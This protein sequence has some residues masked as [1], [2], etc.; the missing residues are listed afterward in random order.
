MKGASFARISRRWPTAAVTVLFVWGV[1]GVSFVGA[2]PAAAKD[3]TELSIED[4]MAMEVTTTVARK[5]QPVSKT[6][7]A[8]FVISSEDIRRSGATCIPE[9]LR[10]VP[11]FEVARINANKWAISAR[12][13]NGYIANKL[14]VLMDGRTVYNQLYSG[15]YWDIQDTVLEDVARI[16]VIRGPGASL[17]G[18][19][20]VNGVV[21]II[22]KKASETQGVMVA[23]GAGTEERF[24]S[25]LRYG[26]RLGK[27]AYYRMYGKFFD[28]DGGDMPDG[29]ESY[30]DWHYGRG[31]GRIDWKRSDS[32][33]FTFQGDIYDGASGDLATYV[34]F[35]P[36]YYKYYDDNTKQSGGNLLGRW[37]H[38]PSSDEDITLQLYFDQTN[39]SYPVLSETRDTYDADFQQRFAWGRRQEV[40]WGLGYRLVHAQIDNSDIVV[41]QNDDRWDQLFSFFVQDEIAILPQKLS[42]LIGSKF[43]KN[44]YTGWETQPNVRLLWTPNEQH[45]VWSAVSRAVRT[46]SQAE[47]DV[48]LVQRIYPGSPYNTMVTF[49]GTEDFLSEQLTAYEAGYRFHPQEAFTIDLAVFYNEY[50]QLLGVEMGTPRISP[51]YIVTPLVASNQLKGNTRGVELAL[52]YQPLPWWRLMGAYTYLEM[53]LEGANS[54]ITETYLAAEGENPRHQVSLRSTM[55]LPCGWALDLWGRYVDDLPSQNVSSYITM[56]ARLGWRPTDNWEFSLV[57]QN[58]LSPSHEEFISEIIEFTPTKVERSVY[59]K[60]KWQF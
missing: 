45:T 26:G 14:L 44:D 30:D 8:V 17:W 36:P 48:V 40:I 22:T 54:A 20:A 27:D 46:P 4:L 39:L 10:M 21:N 34:D 18:A 32:N 28:R 50:D 2:T 43:E 23:A 13:F 7:A 52:E 60:A 15:V 49:E 5:P 57:G 24:F 59:L 3:L 37:Q 56:D 35:D 6:A 12:G 29:G 25:T 51:P 38:T 42:L 58:L 16:E 31:G 11:G 9:L 1:I 41:F 47:E 19:N 33:S 55:D 53:Y